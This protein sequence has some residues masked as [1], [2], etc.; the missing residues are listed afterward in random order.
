[1]KRKRPGPFH[2][3]WS[4]YWRTFLKVLRSYSIEEKVVSMILVVVVVVLGFQGGI[5]LFRTPGLFADDGGIYTEGL[6][7]DHATLINPVY[8]EFSEANRE[9]SSL[10]FSGLTRYDPKTQ[11]FVDD[12]AGLAISGDRKTYKFTMRDGAVWHDGTPLTAADVYFTY[13]DIIQHG[14]FQNP[15]LRANFQGVEV[16]LVDDKTVEFVLSSPNSFFITNLNVGI[17]PKHL[18]ESVPVG[19]LPMSNFNILPVG[20]G[21]YRVEAPLELMGDGRQRVMLTVSDV[22]YGEKSKIQ[23]IRFHI[24]PSSDALLR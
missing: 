23:H 18:L 3:D 15:V 8:A 9:I 12:L 21:P 19:E 24:Y 7:N 4:Q 5:E 16:K 17:L 11:N 10:V 22:Y 6:V 13:H 2:W 20:S 14:E 1:M